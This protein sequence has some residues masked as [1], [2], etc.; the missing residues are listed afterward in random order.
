VSIYY[1]EIPFKRCQQLL[2]IVLLVCWVAT[3]A[4]GF[5]RFV[6]QD[7][8][9]SVGLDYDI[10]DFL[11]FIIAVIVFYLPI[12]AVSAKRGKL[13]YVLG[14]FFY[15]V[16]VLQDV[17][18]L[19]PYFVFYYGLFGTFIWF[20][21]DS[22]TFLK[23]LVVIASGIYIASG[24]H[25]LNP[26]FGSDILPHLWFHSLP[27]KPS[28][29]IGYAIAFL[30]ALLGLGL[31]FR[32]S[33]KFCSVLLVVTHLILIWK[34][35]PFKHSWNL[36]VWPW[37]FCMIALLVTLYNY[38]KQMKSQISTL[39]KVQI[40]IIICFWLLPLLS[41]IGIVPDNLGFKLYSGKALNY[42]LQLERKVEALKPYDRS[43]NPEVTV[44]NLQDYSIRTGELAISPEP[45]IFEHIRRNF[46][47][48]YEM[49]A[50]LI[51]PSDNSSNERD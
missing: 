46:E 12:K 1:P 34:L 48:H 49:N 37:N 4:I 23:S 35:G 3:L 32:Y 7:V 11:S 31:L 41:L 42:N 10:P 43:E 8:L 21:N 36:I 50:V 27:I 29:N 13:F 30:E 15:L 51:K 22:E 45:W 28:Q 2:G 18:R 16:F 6:D 9:L 33:R 38:E 19:T 26:G 5:D 40:P 47:S 20:K 17:N 25:K 44:L 14:L 24:L 39:S